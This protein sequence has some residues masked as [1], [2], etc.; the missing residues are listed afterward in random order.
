MTGVTRL[1]MRT[2]AIL[3]AFAPAETKELARRAWDA[4]VDL[5]EVPVQG[6]AGWA[7]LSSVA[8][9][10]D[11]RPFGAGTVLTADD[12]RRAVDLGASVI[13]SPGIDAAVV[14]A[15]QGAGALALPGVFTPSDVTLAVRLGVSTCKL[16][17]ASL[18]GPQWV[19]QLRGP[20]PRMGIIAVGGV[21]LAN[22]ADYLR[23]G[24]VG[25]GFGS[26]IED[27]LAAPD[28]AA[29]IAALHALATS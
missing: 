27:V 7:A 10:A 15:A 12:A 28:P 9:C 22:A 8:D 11:G 2:V 29:E 20:F 18:V 1:S 26:S 14:E 25:V 23:A 16:F 13:I 24:A 4:G 6:D 19:S 3:R 5:V 17:P 21:G